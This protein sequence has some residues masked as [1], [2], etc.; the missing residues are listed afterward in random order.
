MA[1]G[2]LAGDM[3]RLAGELSQASQFRTTAIDEMRRATQATLAACAT[4]RGELLRDYRG[5]TQKFLSSLAQE[6][7]AQRRAA[8]RHVMKI[9]H[10]RHEIAS[11]LRGR[12]QHDARFLAEQGRVHR[13][14]AKQRK[15][16]EAGRRELG[17]QV[18]SF[19]GAIQRDLMAAHQIWST[20]AHG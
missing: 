10:D 8:S 7:S 19:R 13:K 6:T 18:A 14:T 1:G 3:G 20:L 2:P 4:M 15:S 11:Q 16:L 12:L 9:A 17:A 5:Q